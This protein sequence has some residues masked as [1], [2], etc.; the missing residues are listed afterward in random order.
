MILLQS[1]D[2]DS[3]LLNGLFR[4]VLLSS[5]QLSCPSPL[6]SSKQPLWQL[7]YEEGNFN[8]FLNFNTFLNM[9][10][11]FC[12]PG[13]SKYCQTVTTLLAKHAAEVDRP[14]NGNSPST[15]PEL[16]MLHTQA[17]GFKEKHWILKTQFWFYIFKQKL[18]KEHNTNIPGC[19][20][21]KNSK[22][23]AAHGS[24]EVDITKEVPW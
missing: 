13:V 6:E 14:S 5:K 19:S 1:E 2:T 12:A 9:S 16:L 3:H 23:I 24:H 4:T 21:V 17:C 10:R 11:N 15:C 20:V 7:Q 18:R 8:S 22:D